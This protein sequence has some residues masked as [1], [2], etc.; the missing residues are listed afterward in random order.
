M[1]DP[2][3]ATEDTVP[4]ARGG[5]RWTKYQLYVV[6]LLL[7]VNVS[8][9]LDRT[10]LSVL[11][12]P[13]KAELKLTDSQL[14]MISGPAF[15]LFYALAGVPVARLADRVNRTKLLTFVLSLWS[16]MTALCGLATGFVTLAL[17]RLGVGMGEGG[18]HPIS[19]STIA[20]HFNARQ[21]GTAM[22]LYAA[23]APIA[24]IL[25]PVIGGV[26]A[27]VWGWRTAFVVVGLPGVLLAILIWFT[28]R[29]RRGEAGSP[30]P[31]AR[32]FLEDV[33]WA[34]GNR[35]FVFVFLAGACNGIAITG[36]TVFTTSFIMRV[37]GF[38]LAAAGGVVGLLGLMG[39]A[40]NFIGGFLADRFADARG[41][42][43]VLVPALGAILSLI[44][45]L[46]AFTQHRWEFVFIGL[47]AGNVATDL[48]NG[49]NFAAVQNIVPSRMRATA[50]AFFTLAS[51][52]V[53]VTLGALS[54]GVVSDMAA[55]QQFGAS[56][57]EFAAACPGG[58]P[59][60]GATAELAEA[61]R[62]AS[63]EGL[64]TALA[65]VS[66]MFAGAALFFYLASRTISISRE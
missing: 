54:V 3:R 27:Q 17:C 38:E 60:P 51:N 20:D 28:L 58:R 34:L 66:T 42:S 64:R 8:S 24:S 29:E 9:A 26:V 65:I 5:G 62:L 12:E 1:A 23:G 35:A 47:L 52:V 45:Y 61:C 25:A 48:K 39:L 16:G 44:S 41:R 40:G 15:A 19:H 57:G 13:I 6:A 53:G 33:R 10:I 14:G 59:G 43:Y 21:R 2:L 49:P 30:R 37:H 50:S 31:A 56:F 4:L 46:I 22:A 32:S 63:A 11:Q 55:A 7:L 36:I 18:C